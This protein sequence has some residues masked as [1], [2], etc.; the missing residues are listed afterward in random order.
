MINGIFK[1]F[2]TFLAVCILTV[3]AVG[4][5][6]SSSSDDDDSIPGI[7]KDVLDIQARRSQGKQLG[8]KAF[9]AELVRVPESTMDL[10]CLPKLN[11]NFSGV[12]TLFSDV[13]DQVTFEFSLNSLCSMAFGVETG[14]GEELSGLL[15]VA[16]TGALGL[17]IPALELCTNIPSVGIDF[18]FDLSGS[19]TN[20]ME[21]DFLGCAITADIGVSFGAAGGGGAS[22]SI[23]NYCLTVELPLLKCQGIGQFTKG[24][25]KAAK[26]VAEAAGLDTSGIDEDALGKI[27]PLSGGGFNGG[28]MFATED[29]EI[30]LLGGGKFDLA[31]ALGVDSINLALK[32]MTE[33]SL[34]LDASFS[35]GVSSTDGLASDGGVS[36]SGGAAVMAGTGDKFWGA[37]TNENGSGTLN[38]QKADM[39]TFSSPGSEGS[40][41]WNPFPTIGAKTSGSAA[42]DLMQLASDEE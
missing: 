6:Y 9:R 3:S 29:E 21:L 5:S 30:S 37:Y 31:N 19:L 24:V 23:P 26:E 28:V 10:V 4:I 20:S 35:A 7:S 38:G 41:V 34:E 36:V 40:V 25:V 42:I 2:I 11:G 18:G 22:L 8:D 16:A 39:N 14:F 15:K 33:V 1:F 27:L 32:G 13:K 17:N 12:A